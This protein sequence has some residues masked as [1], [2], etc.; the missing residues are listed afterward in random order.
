MELPLG[1]RRML[2]RAILESSRSCA[3]SYALAQWAVPPAGAQLVFLRTLQENRPLLCP[4]YRH[5]GMDARRVA[6]TLDDM[7]YL[8]SDAQP[9]VTRD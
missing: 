7:H 4:R 2:G 9:P 3:E 1:R 5:V 8:G 6:V